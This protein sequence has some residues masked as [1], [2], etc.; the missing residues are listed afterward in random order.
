V[1]P[2][3]SSEVVVAEATAESSKGWRWGQ[4]IQERGGGADGRAGGGLSEEA[5]WHSGIRRERVIGARDPGEQG[6]SWE[7]AGEDG[8]V[9][10]ITFGPNG[11]NLLYLVVFQVIHMAHWATFWVRLT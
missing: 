5:H 4:D 11:S 6:G 7:R 1:A 9:V 3:S 8:A 2:P 10:W